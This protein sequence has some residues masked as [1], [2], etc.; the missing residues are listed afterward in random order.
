MLVKILNP[1]HSNRPRVGGGAISVFGRP[2]K[3]LL[4]NSVFDFTDSILYVPPAVTCPAFAQHEGDNFYLDVVEIRALVLPLRTAN[5]NNEGLPEPG[6]GGRGCYGDDGGEKG[7]AN[8]WTG[9]RRVPLVSLLGDL[10]LEVEF[11]STE[12]TDTEH[13]RGDLHPERHLRRGSQREASTEC[14]S[15]SRSSAAQPTEFLSF[16]SV[17]ADQGLGGGVSEENLVPLLPAPAK[18]KREG[19]IPPE[20][21]G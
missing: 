13:Q 1:R 14:V 18:A 8:S 9:G 4:Y 20:R 7:S 17:T 6:S 11:C 16:N 5:R 2:L 12:P 21:A 10:D 15:D 19:I 3:K